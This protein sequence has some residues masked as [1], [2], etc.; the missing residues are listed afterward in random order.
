MTTTTETAELVAKALQ[1]EL[2][3][4]SELVRRHQGAAHGYAL[5]Q[6]KD[7][8]AAEDAVQDAFV[9]AYLHL[10]QL[11]TPEAFGGWLRRVVFKHC[12]RQRRRRRDPAQLRDERPSGPTPDAI[13]E[14]RRKRERLMTAI[15]TLPEHERFVVALHYLA[16]QPLESIGDFLSL[17]ISTVK[18]RLFTA[19]KRLRA[20]EEIMNDSAIRTQGQP[21]DVRV[22]LFLAIRAGDHVRVRRLLHEHPELLE[23][24]ERW[25][26]EEALAGGFSLA[27]HITP[28]ILAAGYGDC[29]MVQTLLDLGASPEGRCGCD[30]GEAALWAATR[31]GFDDVA[32][33]LRRAG[34]DPEAANRKAYDAS[35]LERWRARRDGPV[36][37]LDGERLSLGIKA[38]DLWMPLERGSVVVVH[39]AA[40]TGLTV[41]LS[42]IAGAIG[43]AAGATVWTSWEPRAWHRRE[44]EVLAARGAV[45]DVVEI[46]TA[47]DDSHGRDGVVARGIERAR[48]RSAEHAIVAHVIFEQEGHAAEVEA[49]YPKLADAATVTFVV[50]P[51]SAVTRGERNKPSL[52]GPHHAVLCTDPRLAARNLWPAIDP[53]HTRSSVPDDRSEA[54]RRDAVLALACDDAPDGSAEARGRRILAYLTQPFA[55]CEPDTGM[56]GIDTTADATLRD[57]ARILAGG[58]EASE[59]ELLYRGPLS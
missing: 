37:R 30:N 46:V 16:G 8:G 4:F 47:T 7:S 14:A 48:A 2:E 57:V 40:E 20:E 11:R 26:D 12:D 24:E 27:H 36:A 54:A 19:R 53:E 58:V 3:A 44:L 49:A 45:D 17:P 43:R 10:R 35:A 13:L 31:A 33:L 28:L 23:A 38:L 25:S 50:R 59:Q 55:C 42:E 29:D 18:K 39:G 6:L 34:A 41:L 32:Q 21:L 9:D 5:A 51:W 1:G 56:P 22:A 52:G 15:E